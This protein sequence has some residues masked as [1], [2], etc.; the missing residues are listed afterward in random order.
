MEYLQISPKNKNKKKIA[1]IKAANIKE[2]QNI[3]IN[4][5]MRRCL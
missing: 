5:N 3:R 2:L 1:L 4:L